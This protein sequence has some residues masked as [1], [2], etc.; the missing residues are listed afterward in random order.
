MKETRRTLLCG[1][2]LVIGLCL[3][4]PLSAYAE[5]GNVTLHVKI[6]KILIIDFIE[7]PII[8]RPY[9]DWH[10]FIMVETEGQ[11]LVA[12]HLMW[13]CTWLKVVDKVHTFNI[14]SRFIRVNI[15]LWDEDNL[16]LP[17][18]ADISSFTGGGVDNT[19]SYTRGAM[20]RC[21]YDVKLNKLLD[22]DQYVNDSG[23]YMT[24]GEFD[25]S[26]HVEENDAALWFLI[27][28]DY[29]GPKADA[30]PDLVTNTDEKIYF[31]GSSSTASNGSILLHY[32]WDL[33][34]DGEYDKYGKEVS[35][36][37]EV[38][39]E[40][41]V[42]LRVTDSVGEIDE[43][44]CKIWVGN[45]PPKVSFTFHPKEPTIEDDILFMDFSEDL[46]GEVA[47]WLWDF[48]DGN[49]SRERDPVHKFLDKGEY[50]VTLSAG[51]DMMFTNSTS[52][53]ITVT[54]L[55]PVASFSFSPVDPEPG[56]TV[57]FKE[58]SWDPEGG[59]IS[60]R[61]DF[62]DGHTSNESDPNHMF[63]QQEKYTVELKVT[64]DEGAN[65]TYYAMI[66]IVRSHDLTL[67]V[68]DLFGLP[69]ANAEVGLYRDDTCVALGRTDGNGMVALWGVKEGNYEVHTRSLLLASTKFF[70][71]TSSTN[72]RVQVL[73]SIYM[74]GAGAVVV[75]LLA[76]LALF[77]YKKYK[78]S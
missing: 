68:R 58:S 7:D 34:G 70:S 12:D 40:Y 33:D 25:G 42:T 57:A 61:W 39:G 67:E 51:D 32:D 55:P 36:V 17:E 74:L 41:K 22:T 69:V 5:G 27:W 35:Y 62:G 30:G 10:Y 28:D 23:Y 46:E 59:N 20:F 37:Y 9:A 6:R 16:T 29:E 56:Q 77:L 76:G 47:S 73:D 24:S 63:Q 53:L 26:L 1:L 66:A 54:N 43:D 49:T 13:K 31:D 75:A 78:P 18:L 15:Y 50:L 2:M 38:E 71:I 45:S 52:Q 60:Y 8:A 64:D 19:D 65:D 44:V 4:I 3:L 11:E 48:G 21:L 72:E 14:T